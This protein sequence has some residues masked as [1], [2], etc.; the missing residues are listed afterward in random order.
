M[1]P[2]GIGSGVAAPDQ[3]Q[4]GQP[5]APADG[6]PQDSQ[7]SDSN[8][9]PEEQAMYDRFV[10]NGLSIIYPQGTNGQVSPVVMAH[11]SGQLEPEA[12]QQFAKA[13]PPL[14][15]NPVDNL[16]TSAVLIVLMLESS[17][18]QANHPTPPEIVMHGGAE[19]LGELADIATAAKIHDYSEKEIEGATYRGMDLYRISSPFMDQEGAAQE[20]GQ[21]EQADRDGS[22][23]QMIPSLFQKKAG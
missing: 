17:A 7:G 10:K 5:A 13:E 11:L 14:A 2:M 15:G 9:S 22:L 18:A 6:A 16:A 3:Q 21:I 4:A 12:Q 23:E 19:L 1:Q 8:V 20:F